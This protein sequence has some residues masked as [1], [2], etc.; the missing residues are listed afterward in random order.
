MKPQDR[1]LRQGKNRSHKP[2]SSHNEIRGPWASVGACLHRA[3]LCQMTGTDVTPQRHRRHQRLWSQQVCLTQWGQKKARGLMGGNLEDHDTKLK[4]I[5]NPKVAGEI[6]K[7]T[8][9]ED[10]ARAHSTGGKVTRVSIKVTSLRKKCVKSRIPKK[11]EARRG[12]FKVTG[13]ILKPV[14]WKAQGHELQGHGFKVTERKTKVT[15]TQAQ[16]CRT[17]HSTSQFWK[18]PQGQ[19]SELKVTGET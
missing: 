18:K 1:G 7:V 17:D 12:T 15:G 5:E 13:R 19:K 11:K 9:Q 4:V 2:S 8:T 6:V 10:I 14:R 16:D 3:A